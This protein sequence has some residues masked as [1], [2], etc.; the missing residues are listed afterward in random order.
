MKKNIGKLDRMARIV[1]A[2]IIGILY[3]T[4]I[5]TGTLAIVL[6]DISSSVYFY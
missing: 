5:I 2:L 3:A 6:N 4:N 1:I